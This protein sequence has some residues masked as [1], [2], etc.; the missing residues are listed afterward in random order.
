MPSSALEP[1][2]YSSACR[3]LLNFTTVNPKS[4]DHRSSVA[5][6]LQ[7]DT[8]DAFLLVAK[9]FSNCFGSTSLFERQ[10]NFLVI[11][12]GARKN[13]ERR[14]LHLDGCKKPKKGCISSVSLPTCSCASPFERFVFPD[15]G[16]CHVVHASWFSPRQNTNKIETFD[17]F[18]HC[19]RH[20]CHHCGFDHGDCWALGEYFP[21]VSSG[22]ILR[23]KKSCFGDQLQENWSWSQHTRPKNC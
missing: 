10:P 20:V 23:P 6:S 2:P 12:P 7:L 18:S 1:H 13:C 19:S 15:F 21:F 17:K 16:T 4:A 5:L 14:L 8:F 9:P 3:L 22:F 11:V